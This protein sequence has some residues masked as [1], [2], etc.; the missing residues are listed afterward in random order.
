MERMPKQ[1]LVLVLCAD[2][3]N[4]ATFAP[5]PVIVLKSARLLAYMPNPFFE[6]PILNSPYGYPSHHWE[7]DDQGQPTHH[8]ITSRRKA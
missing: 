7:L 2:L 8:I 6:H 4:M 5:Q 1:T 3:I